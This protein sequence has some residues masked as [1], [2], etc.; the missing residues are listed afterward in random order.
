[1][2]FIVVARRAV[3]AYQ[4]SAAFVDSGGWPLRVL[5]VPVE[6]PGGD[7]DFAGFSYRSSNEL[8]GLQRL[9][10]AKSCSFDCQ[11]CDQPIYINASFTFAGAKTFREKCLYPFVLICSRCLAKEFSDSAPSV[12]IQCADDVMWNCASTCL[13]HTCGCDIQ[14]VESFSETAFSHCKFET[15]IEAMRGS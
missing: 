8:S 12:L 10:L 3:F 9:I 11:M 4:W 13:K 15:F 6:A 5:I 14:I 2:Q 7:G 1:M